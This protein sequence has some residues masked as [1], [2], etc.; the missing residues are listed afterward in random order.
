MEDVRYNTHNIFENEF[1]NSFKQVQEAN[2]LL[3]IL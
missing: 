1:T 2:K 3:K